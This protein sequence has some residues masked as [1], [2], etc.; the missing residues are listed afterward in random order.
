MRAQVL[1]GGRPDLTGTLG[2]VRSSTEYILLFDAAKTAL[3]AI[4]RHVYN[5]QTTDPSGFAYL[6]ALPVPADC[7]DHRHEGIEPIRAAPAV[8]PPAP[9]EAPTAPTLDRPLPAYYPEAPSHS[10]RSSTQQMQPQMLPRIGLAPSDIAPSSRA[11]SG[12]THIYPP[13]AA[14]TSSYYVPVQPSYASSSG[15][16]F[17]VSEQPGHSSGM[18]MGYAPAPALAPPPTHGY[19]HPYGVSSGAQYPYTQQPGPSSGMAARRPPTHPDY[20]YGS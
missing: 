8:W 14:S 15:S 6:R 11:A 7:T 12:N 19:Q 4:P 17:T 16:Q 13:T 1:S 3:K 5:V 2:L 10:R 9:T 18:S 20:P